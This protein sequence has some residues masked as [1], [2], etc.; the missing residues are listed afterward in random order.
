[1]KICFLGDAGS[2]HLHKW[3]IYFKKIGWDVSVISFKNYYI[4]GVE[5]ICLNEKFDVKESGANYRY[6]L[7]IAEIRNL[8]KKINPDIVNAHYI[9]SYGF[10]ASVCKD[11]LLALSAWGSDILV[12]PK[13]NPVYKFITKY[14]LKRADIITSDSISMS[15][16][17]SELLGNKKCEII[18]VPM[19]VEI[20][21][22]KCNRE[23]EV[24]SPKILS[25]RTLNENSNIHLIIHA[26]KKVLDKYPNAQLIIANDGD[27]KVSLQEL[28]KS[29]NILDKVK[30]LGFV[31]RK[32]LVDL[33]QKSDYCISVPSSD[34]TSVTLLEAM[35]SGTYPIV[36][37]IKANNEW[38]TD[39][40]NGSVVGF[41]SEEIAECISETYDNANYRRS[42]SNENIKLIERKATLDANM[43]EINQAFLKLIKK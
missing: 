28:T 15:K 42:V 24:D 17:I 23:Y 40:V 29:L 14:A 34:A 41:T 2:L 9:T 39:K 1:M 5:I 38:I 21:I 10:L 31:D 7:Y 18:T 11:R 13:K 43:N 33:M 8:I 16:S 30:F 4:Q 3:I 12:T 32:T 20:D 25:L 19:G 36:S 6:L 22:F 26:F 37:N 27:T 35:A